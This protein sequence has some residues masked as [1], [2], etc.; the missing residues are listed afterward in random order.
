MANIDLSRIYKQAR[1]KVSPVDSHIILNKAET[2]NEIYSDLK[3]DLEFNELKER[4]LNY[5]LA[6]LI[7]N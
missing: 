2:D 6:F 4:P 3:L 7:L 5:I 1:D